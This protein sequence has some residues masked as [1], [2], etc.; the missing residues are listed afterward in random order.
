MFKSSTFDNLA[1]LQRGFDLPLQD[2]LPGSFPVISSAGHSGTHAEYMVK[3]PGVVTGRSGTIGLVHYYEGDYWPLNTTLYV[4]DFK[5]NLPKYVAL[6]LENMDL[7]HHAAGSTV[8][9][10]NRNVLQNVPVRIPS[11]DDQQRIVDLVDSL[12]A[13]I[14]AKESAVDSTMTLWWRLAA[15]MAA[16]VADGPFVA[17]TDIADIGGG[18]TKSRKDQEAAGLVE[19]PYLRV[20]NVY[21]GYLNLSD[22]STIRTSSQKAMRLTLRPGDVLMN[23]ANANPLELGRGTVW[24][25]EVENCIHQNHVFRVRLTDTGFIPEF[26]SA[27]TNTFGQSWFAANG[28]QV[29]VASI[30]KTTLSKFPVPLITKS[31]QIRWSEAL[32]SLFQLQTRTKESADSLRRVRTELLS[33]LLSGAHRIPETYDELMGA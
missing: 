28:T 3:G 21:R 22:V 27:W 7:K 13:V 5:G 4:K 16:E 33:S 29:G 14:G 25:G 24:R 10:L 8:P 12:D 1:T 11:N 9:S 18:L 32:D 20:A 17:L 31:D 26:L 19:V 30:S 23:E 2:R 15:E 6:V